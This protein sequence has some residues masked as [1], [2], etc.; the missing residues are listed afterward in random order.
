MGLFDEQIKQVE[1]FLSEK[2]SLGQLRE[3]PVTPYSRWPL[4]STLILE[5][6]TGLELGNPRM[7]SLS[8]LLYSEVPAADDDRIFLI[9]PDLH[10]IQDKSVP[11]GQIVLVKGTFSDEYE[12]YRELT[13]AVYDTRLEGFMVRALPGRGT[14]WCRVNRE[15]REKGFMLAYLGAA[16]IRSLKDVDF[17]S[18][19]E[20]LFITSGKGDVERL[21]RPGHETGRI[22]GALMKMVEEKTYD[23]ESCE[24]WDV[25]EDV[26]ELKKI[27]SKLQE[28]K[29]R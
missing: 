8:F 15:A 7:G 28:E 5:E 18:G 4:E 17:V 2:K 29:V 27:R 26:A 3:L 9:G 23:C 22:V 19:A 12:C 11:F 25:C 14:I 20:V 24:Y 6:D 1:A 21:K 16:L 13:E 10:E